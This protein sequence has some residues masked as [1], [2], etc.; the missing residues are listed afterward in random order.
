MLRWRYTPVFDKRYSAVDTA[1]SAFEHTWTFCTRLFP[2]AKL[3]CNNSSHC[4]QFNFVWIYWQ[5]IH[6]KG[7]PKRRESPKAWA[8]VNPLWNTLH[9]HGKHFIWKIL[10]KF[11]CSSSSCAVIPTEWP[12]RGSN[13]KAGLS[14]WS[15]CTMGEQIACYNQRILLV[16]IEQSKI[17][18]TICLKAK[19]S[20]FCSIIW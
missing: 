4:K 20:I 14:I 9:Q 8:R 10:Y 16:R 3:Q 12:H 13:A 15:V 1:Q 6:I 5:K 18:K 2:R 7:A 11:F 17:L 19:S